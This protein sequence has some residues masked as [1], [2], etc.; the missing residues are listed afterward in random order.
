[1]SEHEEKCRRERDRLTK[2]Y[3]HEFVK[4][5]REI[6]EK[7]ARE[8]VEKTVARVDQKRIVRGEK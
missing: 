6:T 3:M 4:A 2:D 8:F 7:A 5:G 1:M